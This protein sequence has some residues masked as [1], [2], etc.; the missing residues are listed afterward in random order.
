MQVV[1]R[2][3]ILPGK[4]NELRKWTLEKEKEGIPNAPGWKYLG[5]YFTSMGFGRFDMETRNEIENYAAIDSWRE[6]PDAPWIKLEKEV[7]QFT[8]FS[9][10]Y[11]ITI[12]RE[13]SE[14]SSFSFG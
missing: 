7:A 11:E 9:R 13:A 8:D 2:F 6:N 4:E 14:P 10:P 3:H 5:T 1:T 12:L